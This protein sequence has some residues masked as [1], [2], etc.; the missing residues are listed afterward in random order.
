MDDR[1]FLRDLMRLIAIVTIVAS[2]GQSFYYI[3]EVTENTARK[4]ATYRYKPKVNPT[5]QYE[6]DSTDVYYY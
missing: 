4:T 3:S 2:C 6:S 5:Y 1:M